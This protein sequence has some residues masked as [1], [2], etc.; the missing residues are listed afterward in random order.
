MF[1]GVPGSP[2]YPGSQQPLQL[3]STEP[4]KDAQPLCKHAMRLFDI[5][6]LSQLAQVSHS[7]LFISLCPLSQLHLQLCL[8]LKIRIVIPYV[9]NFKTIYREFFISI[10]LVSRPVRRAAAINWSRRCLDIDAIKEYL[11]LFLCKYQMSNIYVNYYSIQLSN[12]WS[13]K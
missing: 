11:H 10:R 6:H 12:W 3:L 2:G 1:K 4:W 5:S 9:F 13:L 8:L 7:S